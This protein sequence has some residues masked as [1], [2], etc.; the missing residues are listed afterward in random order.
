MSKMFFF[1]FKVV[2]IFETFEGLIFLVIFIV[3]IN[4]K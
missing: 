4:L 1:L 3:T 2:E